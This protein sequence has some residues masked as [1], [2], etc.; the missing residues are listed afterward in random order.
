MRKAP[1][2]IQIMPSN[3][4]VRATWDSSACEA[5]SPTILNAASCDRQK[6][7]LAAI[8]RFRSLPRH[9]QLEAVLRRDEV[10]VV[11]LLQIDLDPV[12]LTVE[13]VVSVVVVG[14][15]RGPSSPADVT[16][17]ICSERHRHRGFHA[18]FA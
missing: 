14:G 18:A 16:C 4:G 5:R 8:R 7:R 15:N 9:C 17:L 10:I 12:H 6:P 2:G 1:P 11:V 3:G 13:L